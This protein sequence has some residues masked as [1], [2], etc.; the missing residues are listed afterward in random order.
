[1]LGVLVLNITAGTAGDSGLDLTNFE[2]VRDCEPLDLADKE[3]LETSLTGCF[4]AGSTA[5]MPGSKCSQSMPGMCPFSEMKVVCGAEPPQLSKR[6]GRF[7]ERRPE[8]SLSHSDDLTNRNLIR[9]NRR[10]VS[11]PH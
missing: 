4:P 11:L 2:L 9:G 5:R 3:I 6:Q 7:R 1:M 10:W 8:G